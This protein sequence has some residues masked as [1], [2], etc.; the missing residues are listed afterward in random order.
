[1]IPRWVDAQL[2]EGAKCHYLEQ[3]RIRQ[4]KFCETIQS[5]I[6]DESPL[7]KKTKSVQDLIERVD[8]FFRVVIN[9]KNVA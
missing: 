7:D 1:M 6:F 9:N 2:A 4:A 5:F 3:G 8:N